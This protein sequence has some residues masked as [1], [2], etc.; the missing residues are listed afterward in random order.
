MTDISHHVA[1][2]EAAHDRIGVV[3]TRVTSLEKNEAVA[4]ERFKHI[5]GSLDDI[6]GTISKVAWIVITA[7]LMAILTF[8]LKGGM[9]VLGS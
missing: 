1:R 5:V 7:V 4:D 8:M 6:K 9:N 3:E 2:I